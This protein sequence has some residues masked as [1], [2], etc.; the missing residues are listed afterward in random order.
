MDEVWRMMRMRMRK[1]EGA[2]LESVEAQWAAHP[3]LLLLPLHAL[4]FA[5]PRAH[6]FGEP[7]CPLVRG[8]SQPWFC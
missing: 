6:W 1:F 7:F 2:C 8:A 3:R 5:Y 4:H